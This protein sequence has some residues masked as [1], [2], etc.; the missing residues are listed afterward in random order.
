VGPACQPEEK[1]G[2]RDG[3]VRQLLAGPAH[4]RGPRLGEKGNA[5]G[6]KRERRGAGFGPK[7]R[8]KS[9]PFP[10]LFLILQIH[11]SNDFGNNFLLEINQIKTI[12]NMQRHVCT[13]THLTLYLILF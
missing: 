6:P 4:H 3:P 13:N 12:K 9:F 11:F 8:K 5:A 7:L 1:G 2:R 10:F